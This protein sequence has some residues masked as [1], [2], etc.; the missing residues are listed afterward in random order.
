VSYGFIA[1]YLPQNEGFYFAY[2]DDSFKIADAVIYRS[3]INSIKSSYC[4]IHS[5]PF[6]FI[7]DRKLAS[8]LKPKLNGIDNG[9]FSNLCR[10]TLANSDILGVLF[11]ILEASTLSLQPMAASYSVALEALATIICK[12]NEEKVTPI[13]D[14]NTAREMRKELRTVLESYKSRI[15][16]SGAIVLAKKIE[17]INQ[18][19]NRDKLSKPF[20]MYALALNKLDVEAIENRNAF[21]H[22]RLPGLREGVF[23][24]EQDYPK[25]YFTAL[26]LYFLVTAL[27]LKY[28][29]FSGLIP[30]YTK[31]YEAVTRVKTGESHFREI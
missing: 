31:M 20:E 1:G 6:A 10:I 16:E 4:A 13:T 27:V 22:G 12:E 3:L 15:S 5:N 17:N 14:K 28:V 7:E 23:E 21:L 2:K 24:F 29:G 25:L 19:T 30:N 18:P 8:Q 26:R 9:L 11:L